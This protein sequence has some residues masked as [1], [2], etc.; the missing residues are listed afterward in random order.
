MSWWKWSASQT[1]AAAEREEWAARDDGSSNTAAQK[2]LLQL[3]SH[4][5]LLPCERTMSRWKTLEMWWCF[6]IEKLG[7]GQ[8]H[9]STFTLHQVVQVTVHETVTTLPFLISIL[10]L[11]F[12]SAECGEASLSW[13]DS[14]TFSLSPACQWR[15][16]LRGPTSLSMFSVSPG[17]KNT[18]EVTRVDLRPASATVDVRW[19]I[20]I[21]QMCYLSTEV[22]D[23]HLKYVRIDSQGVKT[24]IFFG[25]WSVGFLCCKHKGWVWMLS[26]NLWRFNSR[27][28]YSNI[29]LLWCKAWL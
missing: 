25:G 6:K 15:W 19:I 28:R 5:V 11:N 10:S 9:K 17:Q 7:G 22:T 1:E 21:C 29:A 4:S 27:Y 12:A 3:L 16:R 24:G 14:S 13:G 8:W 18:L 20:N 2:Q 26:W 23:K